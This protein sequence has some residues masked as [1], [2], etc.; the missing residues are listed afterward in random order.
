MCPT[1]FPATLS[2]CKRKL[3][4]LESEELAV[5]VIRKLHLAPDSVEGASDPDRNSP[6]QEERRLTPGESAA[7]RDF[8]RQLKLEHDPGSH[9]I[10][11]CRWQS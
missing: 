10:S 6:A 4:N 7:L 9:L 2:T 3:Q 1:W 8:Q 5:A 11:N